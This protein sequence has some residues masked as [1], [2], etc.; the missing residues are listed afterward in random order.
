M[1]SKAEMKSKPAYKYDIAIIGSGIQGIKLALGLAK[2][3]PNTKIVIV[4]KGKQLMSGLSSDVGFRGQCGL[5]YP[6]LDQEQRNQMWHDT[7]QFARDF[8]EISAR[9]ET[10]SYYF[11]R[12]VDDCGKPSEITAEGFRQAA[13]EC[14]AQPLAKD[15]KGFILAANKQ[16]A[17]A[18]VDQAWKT[19]EH[20]WISGKLM[21][22][23]FQKRLQQHPNITLIYQQEVIKIGK[24][25]PGAAPFI[26]LR[27]YS[28]DTRRF[29]TKI[30][31]AAAIYDCSGCMLNGVDY[32]IDVSFRIRMGFV[33][34]LQGH[35]NGPITPQT[36]AGIMVALGKHC[37][38]MP[39]A[40][41]QDS[42]V[43]R[44]MIT[45]AAYTTLDHCK[46]AGEAQMI[47]AELHKKN[48]WNEKLR[49]ILYDKTIA[50]ITKSWPGFSQCFKQDPVGWKAHALAC[51]GN[52]RG[53]VY[54]TDRDTK[55][56]H[57][58]PTKIATPVLGAIEAP[59]NPY[60]PVPI[61]SAAGE[62]Q[63]SKRWRTTKEIAALIKQ[64]QM[65]EDHNSLKYHTLI[66]QLQENVNTRIDYRPRFRASYTGHGGTQRTELHS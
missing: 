39:I 52:K 58:L 64:D 57:I 54:L 23:A 55:I 3:R 8:P 1:G 49:K 36:P 5:H 45:H 35:G 22:E 41:D 56:T 59:N 29:I 40:S 46:T 6:L 43:T 26:T 10:S 18:T 24:P 15:D 63:A 4:E 51:A 47:L 38:L 13:N 53:A 37:S 34:E 28:E 31:T 2:K 48:I 21:R 44:Y 12:N 32:P 66:A 17:I 20:W 62:W 11:Y 7:L 9:G 60:V 19:K 25:K 61:K 50:S 42:D 14:N 16:H 30:L 27:S 65:K 33:V